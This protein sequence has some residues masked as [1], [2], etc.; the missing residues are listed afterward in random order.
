MSQAKPLALVLEDDP[1]AS[2][3]LALLLQ[4]WGAEVVL[5][6]DAVAAMAAVAA[7]TEQLRWIITDYHLGPGADGV[8]AARLIATIAPKARVLV[9]TGAPS[10]QVERHATSAGF[11]ILSK[12]A[13]AETILAWLERA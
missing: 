7:R 6:V 8:S 11:E 2:E 1:S 12:P 5:G 9:L 4:D 3:A 13:P 10:P